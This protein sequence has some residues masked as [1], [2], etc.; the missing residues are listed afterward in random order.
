LQGLSGQAEQLVHESELSLH[1]VTSDPA[2]LEVNT[3]SGMK[4]NS[5]GPIP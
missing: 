4:P 1:M 5:F 3:G 2:H